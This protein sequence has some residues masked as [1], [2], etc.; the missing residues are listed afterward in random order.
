MA[1]QEEIQDSLQKRVK[2][3]LRVH[4]PSENAYV[5]ASEAADLARAIE[6]ADAADKEHLLTVAEE[7]LRQA[8]AKV[9]SLKRQIAQLRQTK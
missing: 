3:Y 7:E 4:D 6:V 8:Q 5:V 9:E 1:V 2:N